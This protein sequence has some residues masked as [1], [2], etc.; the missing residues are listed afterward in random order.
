MAKI[1]DLIKIQGGYS[2]Q[3]KLKA[4]FENRFQNIERM[5]SYMPIKSHRRAFEAIAEGAYM[6]NSKRCFVLSGSYGTGKSHLCLMA[7]NY[8]ESPSTTPEMDKYFQNYSLSEEEEP[9]KKSEILK[10]LRKNGRYLVAICDYELN[11]YFESVVLRAIKDACEREGIQQ[12]EIDSHYL[13][14]LTKIE[15][16]ESSDNQYFHDELQKQLELN[17]PNWTINRLRKALKEFDRDGIDIFKEIHKKITTADFEYDKDNVVEI[18]KQLSNSETIKDKFD[19]IVILYDEFDYQLKNKRFN[20]NTFQSFAEMCAGSILN[21]FPI[22]FVSTIHR[23][24]ISYK[25]VYNAEDFGT[26][27]DRIKEIELQTE[28]IEDIIAAIVLPQTSS[29]LWQKEIVPNSGIFNQL[30]AQSKANKIFS[31]LDKGPKLKKKIIENIYPMHPM[32]TYALIKL[33]S[34]VGSNNRSV[35][36]FF[37]DE[38]EQPGSYDWFVK[39]NNILNQ[40]GELQFFTANLLFDY[41][42]NKITTDNPELRSNIKDFIRDYETSVRELNKLRQNLEGLDFSVELYDKI[43]K[44]M[45]IQQIIGVPSSYDKIKFSL[46]IYTEAQ[47]KELEF[48]LK[49]AKDKKIIFFNDTNSC[50][51]FRKSDAVDLSNLISDFKDDPANIPQDIVEELTS[52]TKNENVTKL[53]KFFKNEAYLLPQDYNSQFNEDKRLKRTFITIKEV[54]GENY[55]SGLEKEIKILSDP[56]SSYEGIA[57]YVICNSEDEVRRAKLAAINNDSDKIIVGVP[58]EEIAIFDEVFSLK[59]VTAI[60]TDDFSVQDKGLLKEYIRTYD[61]SLSV[62]LGQYIVS[63]NVIYYGKSGTELTKNHL[64][65]HEAANKLMESLFENKRNKFK[66]EDLNILHEFKERRNTALK[67]AVESI[68]DFSQNITFN[69]NW[70]ADRGDKRYIE[71]VLYNCNIITAISSE[72]GKTICNLEMDIAKYD[73]IFPA[74]GDMIKTIRSHESEISISDFVKKY[75]QD[76]GLGYNSIILFFAIVLRYFKDNLLV[77]SDVNEIGN[78]KVKSYDSL[79]DLIYSQKYKNAVLRYKQISEIEMDFIK[80]LYKT[81]GKYEIQGQAA[82]SVDDV[83]SVLKTWYKELLNVAKIKDIYEDN[84]LD[85]FIEVFSKI[86]KVNAHDFVLDELKTIYGYEK[87]DLLLESNIKEVLKKVRDDK[88]LIERGYDIVKDNIITQVKNIFSIDKIT[89]DDILA[90]LNNWYVG[91]TELQRNYNNDLHDDNSRALVRWIGKENSLEELFMNKIPNSNDYK[92]GKVRDWITSKQNSYIEKIRLGKK[93]IEENI[94]LVDPPV[95]TLTG[96]NVVEEQTDLGLN[97]SYRTSV[98]V[99]INP[100]EVHQKVYVTSNGSNPLDE[101]AQRQELT[102][103][104]EVE[105]ND[106]KTIKLAGVDAN[107]KVSKT[108]TLIF[109]NKNKEY[110]VQFI[111]PKEQQLRIGQVPEKLELKIQVTL[112][113]D[114]TS[115]KTC[116]VSLINAAKE[117]NKIKAK[118]LKE[119]LEELLREM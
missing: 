59:A 78:L 60:N 49:R 103:A 54:E 9:T 3:V 23:S 91:L 53:K 102:E 1:K 75:S 96:Q 63:K 36:T 88:E 100:L 67:E 15:E 44:V 115:L 43:L 81:F 62:K 40:S 84:K 69:H 108:I 85:S 35:F 50:Y 13:Q 95:Y 27:N 26:V 12:E 119:T 105:I 37:A 74:L 52:L 58:S 11:T 76:Y 21:G 19:G 34:D 101:S 116:F 45:V 92:L 57:L 4:E 32:A 55:F 107:G 8:F 39:N 42:S 114:K 106:N 14:A 77:I 29:A 24:F 20:L 33:A 87:D 22:I 46:N 48:C 61:D 109:L 31:W 94:F 83:Y 68:L 16:W 70:A 118:D 7:A 80:E 113:K 25:S 65:N 117:K 104:Y 47:E 41:F 51:E 82:I 18:I 6:K 111:P 97:I 86:D 73:K 5:S 64:S 17:Y 90:D 2:A 72:Q 10:N 99:S 56:K 110:E 66:H 112:P 38:S 98:K 93:H 30:A 28:G 89:Y 79:L 71:K